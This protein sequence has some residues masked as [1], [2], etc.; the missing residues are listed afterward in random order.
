MGCN[1]VFDRVLPAQ[2]DRRVNSSGFFFFLFFLTQLD[3]NP[4]L[5]GSW[6]TTKLDQISKLLMELTSFC[7]YRL[8]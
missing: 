6:I 4:E 7:G 3:F 2:P 8:L 1:W 5:A